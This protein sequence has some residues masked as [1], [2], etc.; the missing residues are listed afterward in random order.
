MILIFHL[1]PESPQAL[2]PLSAMFRGRVNRE[3]NR[4]VEALESKAEKGE[5]FLIAPSEPVTV[6]RLDG[7]MDK[8]GDLYW[9]GYNDMESRIDELKR[10][11]G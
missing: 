11:I 2:F 8:L 3:F 9:L 5:I 4:T 7:D 10:F 6:K 1:L